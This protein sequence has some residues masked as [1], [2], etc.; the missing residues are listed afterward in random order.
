M[1]D[2]IVALFAI[3]IIAASFSAYFNSLRNEF[4]WDD[5]VLIAENERVQDWRYLGEN[6]RTHLYHGTGEASNFYRPV[7]KLSFMLDYA[8]WK[9]DVFGW[10]L[11]NIVLHAVNAALV[12][13]IF[14]L[15]FADRIASFIAGMLFAVHPVFTSAVTYISGRGDPLA[16]FFMMLAFLFFIKSRCAAS[17]I[18]F[19]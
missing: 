13:L 14:G 3:L 17:V 12:F 11:T 8:I 2:K 5:K 6:L 19:V 9:E 15:V 7:L 1:K 10:H 18:F 4:V 16:L